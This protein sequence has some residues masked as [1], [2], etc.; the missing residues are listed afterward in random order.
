MLSLFGPH[1]SDG[2]SMMFILAF[3]LLARST[4]GPMERFLNM[5]GQQS[6][7]AIAYAAAFAFNVILCLVLIPPF[8][9]TGAAVAMTCAVLVETVSLFLIARYRL[10][11][12]VFIWGRAA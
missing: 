9:A 11:F 2:Y 5:V 1:F 6:A 12:H 7:C 3:G 10:G 4:I 8:G